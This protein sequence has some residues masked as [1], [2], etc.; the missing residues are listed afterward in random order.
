MKNTHLI[1]AIIAVAAVCVSCQKEPSA[2]GVKDENSISF[3]IGSPATK[4]LEA[5]VKTNVYDLGYENLQLVEEISSMDDL[6]EGP[7]TKGTPAYTE[8]IISLYESFNAVAY[9]AAGS[10]VALADANFAY[11]SGW[12][13]WRHVYASDPWEGN[14]DGLWFFMRMGN[15]SNTSNLSYSVSSSKGVIGF[16]YVSPATASAQ[17]DILFASRSIT[18]TQEEAGAKVLFY[19]VLSG[20][21]FKIGELGD[22]IA[23]IKEITFNGLKDNGHCTVTPD[24]GVWNKTNSNSDGVA[25]TKSAACA[26]W[27]SLT[28]STG[29][30]SPK[31][32]FTDSQ[33]AGQD[34]STGSDYTFPDSFYLSDKGD[35]TNNAKNNL[36]DKNF[37]Q[38]FFLIPQD[39]DE[40]V[41]LTL[42][43]LCADDKTVTLDIPFGA[44]VKEKN[45][46]TAV[47][48]KAGELRTYTFSIDDDA[49][50]T[51]EETL[52]NAVKK[53][54]KIKNTNGMPVYIRAIIVAN[55]C[56]DVVRDDVT[57]S[58]IVAPYDD[59]G[60]YTNL[61]AEG[62]GWV[63]V[64][65]YYYYTEK[66]NANS[67]TTGNLFD[68]FTY[69]KADVPVT[70]AYLVMSIATQAVIAT[71]DFSSYED[72]WDLN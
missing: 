68:S 66:V 56:K 40:N 65:D 7:A 52:E 67:P 21:K 19:H 71:D 43:I 5:E 25:S 29:G 6:F 38:T 69:A 8:N 27:T 11:D 22:N 15:M 32:T 59:E 28:K 41:T 34:L 10:Q 45:N 63:K 58:V 12:G 14:D 54:V 44:M 64:G 55:W 57:K 30:Y 17:Q 4:A 2:N 62:S 37:T 3:I 33:A 20:V 60:T 26:V 18:K 51:I 39:L 16:D 72:A 36:N 48:L 50:I 9:N 23:G 61:A 49:D 47:T 24:Y 53:N 42:K 46:D 1:F 70:G 35:K 31:A 13:S